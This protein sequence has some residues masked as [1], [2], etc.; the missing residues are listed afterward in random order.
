VRNIRRLVAH[1]AISEQLARAT[2]PLTGNSI[3]GTYREL[4]CFAALLGFDQD[5]RIELDGPTDLLVDGRIL[6]NSDQAQD[7]VYLL[8]LAATKEQD[9]LRVDGEHP[10]RL[11]AL[12]EQHVAGGLQILAEWLRDEPSDPHGDRAVLSALRRGG[13]LNEELPADVAIDRVVF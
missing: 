13:Y 1:T 5:R 8:G 9:I 2:H 6:E 3:F 12:F 10:E 4:A 11:V 7:I